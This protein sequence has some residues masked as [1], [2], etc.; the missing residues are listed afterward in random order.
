MLNFPT[1][2]LHSLPEQKEPEPEHVVNWETYAGDNYG[3]EWDRL[4]KAMRT[5]DEV[6]IKNCNDDIDTLLVFVR[7]LACL[8]VFFYV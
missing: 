3:D 8:F 6:K 5:Y 4:S 1:E 2:C 7:V